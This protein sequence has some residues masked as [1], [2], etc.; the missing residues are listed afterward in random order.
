MAFIAGGSSIRI[1]GARW[2][3]GRVRVRS[4]RL[5]DF[6]ADVERCFNVYNVRNEELGVSPNF[7]NT[8]RWR[9]KYLLAEVDDKV[10][11]S[12]TLPDVN[13]AI[14]Q[15]RHH[16]RTAHRTAATDAPLFRRKTACVSISGK[17]DR[18]AVS[19]RTSYPQDASSTMQ[20][21]SVTLLL[22]LAGRSK[23]TTSSTDR[24]SCSCESDTRRTKKD[25]ETDAV[26]L[27]KA[28]HGPRGR[29]GEDAVCRARSVRLLGLRLGQR[30]GTGTS[31]LDHPQWAPRPLFGLGNCC[32]AKAACSATDIDPVALG[33]DR[34]ECGDQ[35]RELATSPRESTASSTH[36]KR[37]RGRRLVGCTACK[38]AADRDGSAR[39]EIPPVGLPGPT[40]ENWRA[41]RC[42]GPCR[43][44]LEHP[45]PWWKPR[46][47]KQV[48]ERIPPT[49]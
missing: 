34:T 15:F 2:P 24:R 30:P 29:R 36:G 21:P 8:C 9:A 17:D 39:R 3:D 25:C 10:G 43:K 28:R 37:C 45:D 13:E 49:Q 27:I 11:F 5:D 20:A 16:P 47:R 48:P 38:Q 23:T 40:W 35:R 7:A 19:Q 14:A 41:L 22:S 1:T 46:F 32:A 33:G 44:P 4:F 31:P 6:D 12:I 18:C 26:P 42:G